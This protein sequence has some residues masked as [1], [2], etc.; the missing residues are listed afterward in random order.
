MNTQREK[1]M[2]LE[3]H[4]KFWNT[5][6]SKQFCIIKLWN[7]SSIKNNSPSK[8]DIDE[9]GIGGAGLAYLFLKFSGWA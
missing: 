5:T 4:H 7:R 1:D 9:I 2:N 6:S 8:D 3:H